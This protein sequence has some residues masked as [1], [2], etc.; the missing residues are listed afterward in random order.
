MINIVTIAHTIVAPFQPIERL[1]HLMYDS[2]GRC[3]ARV[4]S[5]IGLYR[6]HQCLAAGAGAVVGALESSTFGYGCG[7]LVA[8]ASVWAGWF[9]ERVVRCA[10]QSVWEVLVRWRWTFILVLVFV[11][12]RAGVRVCQRLWEDIGRRAEDVE[13]R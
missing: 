2:S 11:E 7:E 5:G 12:L 4:C 3:Q 6:D 13:L 9:A 1:H 8:V 10:R